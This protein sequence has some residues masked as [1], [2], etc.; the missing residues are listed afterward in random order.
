VAHVDAEVTRVGDGW[1][2]DAHVHF[3]GAGVAQQLHQRPGSGAAD[4]R[5]V[6]HHHSLAGEV[7]RE[8]VELECHAALAEVLGGLDERSADVAVLDEAVVVL[9][10]CRSAVPD[11][12]RDGAVGHGDHDIG[13]DAGLDG[14]LLTQSLADVV[15][16]AAGPHA[17]GATEVDEL[18][19]A[20]SGRGAG[21]ERLAASE[22][23]ALQRDDLA[24]LHLV[25][26]DAPERVEGTGLGGDRVAT[27]RQAAHA[28]RAEAPRVANGD[29]PVVD[30]E[31]QGVRTLPRRQRAFDAILPRL[32]AGRGEHQG[33]HLGVA[34][35]RE[36][37]ALG[38]QFFAQCAG[39]HQ[40]AVVCNRQR[41][42][43]RLHQERL[44]VAVC[45]GPGGAV[46][47]VTDRVV[48][49]ERGHGGRR[50]HVGDEAG[51]LVAAHPAA[52]ADGDAG[53]LLAPMLQ[54][55]QAEEG[56]L[57]DAFTVWRGDTEDTTLLLR[58]VVAQAG[59]LIVLAA[60]VHGSVRK[61]EG[62]P[63]CEGRR[64]RRQAGR[65]YR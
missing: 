18:E 53:C 14:Q 47:G 22:L 7:L 6:D 56:Q 61:H 15:H 55:E 19:R 46:A 25:D 9:D 40:V 34:G 63:G 4:Q 8:C 12:R 50:E 58:A 44:M 3:G 32:A 41:A 54:R 60:H 1:A 59:L 13:V 38:Q 26:L 29:D 30:D 24:G 39:V 31:D 5:I 36:S 17:V 23:G 43:H 48:P 52:V 62:A 27:M 37:E 2:R 45:V 65:G 20:A 42:V 10:A 49:G 33:E 11:G 35:G 28:H 21:C 51:V 57:S 64:G 16:V